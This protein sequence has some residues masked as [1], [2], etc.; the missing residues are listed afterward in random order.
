MN[1]D[2]PLH[3]ILGAGGVVANQLAAELAR[4]GQRVRLVG[5][6]PKALGP[7]STVFRADLTDPQQVIAAVAGSAIVYLLVGLKYDRRVW[8]RDWPLIMRNT[9]AACQQAGARL[10]FFDNIYM[11]GRV[12]GPLTETTPF[13]PC[14]RKGEIRGAIA[15]TLLDE[16]KAGWITAAIARS[17]DFYGPGTG[18]STI[19]KLVFDKFAA[20]A[21]A[22]WLVNDSVRY[23]LTFAPDA[24]RSLAVL[25]GSPQAWG[26]TWHVPTCSTPVTARDLIALAAQAF[27]VPSRHSILSRPMIWLAGIFVPLIRE[28]YEMLYQYEADYIFD[29]SRFGGAFAFTPTAYAEGVRLTAAGYR[30]G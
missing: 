13:N 15:T 24:G 30:Q 19:M 17:A 25:A 16:M 1:P 29:S 20:G 4:T 26:Q 28:S 22:S 21:K 7:A 27:G 9:I 11:Y 3:T 5:R 10:I 2:Q 14:S 6:Q 23:S 12:T 8:A 18:N